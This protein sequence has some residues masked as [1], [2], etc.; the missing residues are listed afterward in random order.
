MDQASKA[1]KNFNLRA[2][3]FEDL[4]NN[5]SLISS[6]LEICCGDRLIHLPIKVNKIP[7]LRQVQRRQNQRVFICKRIE[8][9]IILIIHQYK[10]IFAN[11]IF[12]QLF[13]FLQ[14]RNF[15][16]TSTLRNFIII[17]NFSSQMKSQGS[18][19]YTKTCININYSYCMQSSEVV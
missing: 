7:C 4:K 11:H 10:F 13:D 15:V 1:P 12:F 17:Y 18:F 5:K 2:F 14:L 16:F 9:E 6:K 19:D 3:T 8:I